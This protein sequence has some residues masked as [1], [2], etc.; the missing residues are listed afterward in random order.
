MRPHLVGGPARAA[1]PR[2][3]RPRRPRPRP[4]A[5]RDDVVEDGDDLTA[6]VAL[7]VEGDATMPAGLTDAHPLRHSTPPVTSRATGAEYQPSFTCC[8]FRP[9]HGAESRLEAVRDLLGFG[10]PSA[11]TGCY[12]VTYAPLQQPAGLMRLWARVHWPRRMSSWPGWRR[13]TASSRSAW[14]LS[15]SS[16]ARGARTA[17]ALLRS[18]RRTRRRRRCG[19]HRQRSV[20]S[21]DPETQRRSRSKQPKVSVKRQ[22]HWANFSSE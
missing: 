1:D 22:R 16:S 15:P 7:S 13:R 8:G 18:G 2:P 9:Q 17:V 19:Q 11:G 5:R 3:R 6:V 14:I 10:L 21:L 20:I 12:L 4:P